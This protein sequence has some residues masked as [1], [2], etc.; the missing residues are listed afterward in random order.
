MQGVRRAVTSCTGSENRCPQARNRVLTA[1]ARGTKGCYI[2]HK[3]WKQRPA[4]EGPGFW[5]LYIASGKV[6]QMRGRRGL[7]QQRGFQLQPN[8]PSLRPF[9]TLATR[10]FR[11]FRFAPRAGGDKSAGRGGPALPCA[12]IRIDGHSPPLQSVHWQSFAS[13]SPARSASAPYRNTGRQRRNRAAQRPPPTPRL[14]PRSPRSAFRFNPITPPLRPF[15][16]LCGLSG[17]AVQILPI[18]TSRRCDKSAGRGGPALPCAVVR[19]D[20]HSP[21]PRLLTPSPL[22]GHH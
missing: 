19:I 3:H 9:A 7:A 1:C 15:A 6:L 2:V 17:S 10:R 8:H 16:A 21:P 12:A 18:F 20:G 22:R 13:H 4:G 14:P 5:S 11:L